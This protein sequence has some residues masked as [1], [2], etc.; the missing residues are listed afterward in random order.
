MN[1]VKP[2]PRRR[3]A[4]YEEP[5]LKRVNVRLTAEQHAYALIIGEGNLSLGVRRAIEYMAT[6]PREELEEARKIY[7]A[8][9]AP[10]QPKKALPAKPVG[11]PA[12]TAETVKKAQDMY[13]LGQN[14]KEISGALNIHLSTVYKYVNVR[15][16]NPRPAP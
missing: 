8:K 6:L 10:P 12:V 3:I 14:I 16:K 7:Q 13:S 11:H 15:E 1:V 5:P 4:S 9:R 2:K